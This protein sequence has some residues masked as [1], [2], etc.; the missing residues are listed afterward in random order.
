MPVV[1]RMPPPAAK[2]PQ[3]TE[4]WERGERPE[5]DQVTVRVAAAVR[6]AQIRA[7][8]LYY[9]LQRQWAVNKALHIGQQY[10]TWSDSKRRLISQD[11]V[12]RHR[13]R[14]V[15]NVVHPIIQ[16]MTAMLLKNRP[17]WVVMPASSDQADKDSAKV[18][19]KV[20]D[21]LHEQ[22]KMI[23]KQQVCAT[24][25]FQA[26]A[27]FF[28]DGWDPNRGPMLEAI[29]E[30]TG[31][32]ME[33]PDTG[34]PMVDGAGKP[35]RFQPGAIVVEVVPSAQILPDPYAH[36]M[37]D[38]TWI[39]HSRRRSLTWIRE[40]MPE[41][42]K[43]VH[44]EPDAEG[45]GLE[46]QFNSI[47]AGAMEHGGLAT[48]ESD[49]ARVNEMWIRP[50][51]RLEG[52]RFPKGAYI[53]QVQGFALFKEIIELEANGAIPEEDWHPFTMARCYEVGRFW[54]M[55]VVD[56]I[57]P[58]QVQLN[59]VTSG[60]IEWLRLTSKPKW[61]IP[62]SCAI[63]RSAL[64]SEAGEKVT[65]NHLHGGKPEMMAMPPL[66]AT[67]MQFRQMLMDDID[68]VS[69]QHAAS[70]GQAPTGIKSGIGLSLLQE[71]DATDMGPVTAS[72]ELTMARLGRRLLLRVQQFWTMERLVK[73]MGSNGG[74]EVF[75]FSGANL[76][77][78]I[79][80]RV[81]AGSGLPKSKAAQQALA[82]KLVE[83]GMLHPRIPEERRQLFSLLEMGVG[84]EGGL[85]VDLDRRRAKHENELL[86]V[87]MMPAVEYYQ[88]HAA[89]LEEL[90]RWMK[91]DEYAEA[92]ARDPQVMLRANV[93]AAQHAQYMGMAMPGGPMGFQAGAMGGAMGGE[94][95]QPGAGGQQG[96]G[97]G[98]AGQG[99]LPMNG[100]MPTGTGDL[101]GQQA[102][103]EQ[104]MGGENAAPSGPSM[105]G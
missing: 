93:H 97:G 49:W 55:P 51:G 1:G 30:E 22:L 32:P 65:Y 37:D 77:G 41:Y 87:G 74:I 79:D 100:S 86:L 67:V 31:E 2:R 61:L 11:R 85:D 96:M 72:W 34:K 29:D 17:R 90:F 5:M 102:N 63:A 66:P 44:S 10:A 91:G 36:D 25:M 3:T 20:L 9:P 21:S 98:P 105:G 62:R 78:Q 81:E 45:A 56:N 60:I 89:H 50:G 46:Y 84:E 68:F 83:L 7:T 33:D 76:G 99:M 38:L 92:V 88:D 14:I 52:L 12:P 59:N 53:M 64:T 27:C 6:S 82:Q 58:L 95:S 94:D 16:T 47:T 4:A 57:A 42:G 73:V 71:Q 18:S 23:N 26:G 54:P 15:V 101:Q 80:V 70:R 35:L 13:V 19:E 39:I 48:Q 43:F 104:T 8:T 75:H 40:Q 103:Q 28:R 69:I 24:Q